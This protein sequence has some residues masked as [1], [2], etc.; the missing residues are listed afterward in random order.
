MVIKDTVV[1]AESSRMLE[2]NVNF[3]VCKGK[4]KDRMQDLDWHHWH[5]SDPTLSKQRKN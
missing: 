3:R 4:D 5:F 1:G 2:L